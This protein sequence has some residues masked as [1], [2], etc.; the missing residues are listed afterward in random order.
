LRVFLGGVSINFKPFQLTDKEL[1]DSFFQSRRYENAHFNFTNLYMWRKAY[2]IEWAVEA[3]FLFVKASW[4]GEKF[5]LQPFGPDEGLG[6]AISKL[7]DYFKQQNIPLILSGVESSMVAKLD[8]LR[9][10]CFRFTEDRDNYDYLY[11]AQDLITLKGRKFHSKKNHVNSFKKTYSN[12]LYRPLTPDLTEQCIATATEWY[13]RKN[14]GTEDDIMLD[15][16]REAIIDAFA[17][18]EYLKLQGGVIVIDGK[19]EAFAFGER[20]NNDT[21]VI[22]VEKANADIRGIY[23]AINQEFCKNSWH[24]V[25]YI[26]REEDMGLE[27]LRKSKMSYHPVKLIKKYVVTVRDRS[28]KTTSR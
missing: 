26:N 16:E 1:I 27:G 6:M 18:L 24:N 25:R 8:K 10:G 22:H 2:N 14:D 19:V 11:N 12:Y 5:A 23:P 15:Y 20:L 17:N 21:A 7:E 9:P 4:E 28:K 3:D 13:Q